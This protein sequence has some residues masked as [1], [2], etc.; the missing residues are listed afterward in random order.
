MCA[1]VRIRYHREIPCH[2]DTGDEDRFD[3][4]AMS[5]ITSEG[6]PGIVMALYVFFKGGF[7]FNIFPICPI[8]GYQGRPLFLSEFKR[9]AGTGFQEAR[10]T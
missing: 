5:R 9:K 6:D 2:V 7:E 10:V 8:L 4:V 3:I 1:I